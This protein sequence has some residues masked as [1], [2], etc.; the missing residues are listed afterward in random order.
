[1]TGRRVDSSRGWRD[2]DAAPIDRG[3]RVAIE[4]LLRG[5]TGMPA[6]V[7]A[8]SA[9]RAR[10]LADSAMTRAEDESPLEV[11]PSQVACGTP[12]GSEFRRERRP[13]HAATVYRRQGFR[14]WKYPRRSDRVDPPRAASVSARCEG[15]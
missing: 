10:R 13:T 7:S 15:R 3:S 4:L 5:G 12:A 6:R 2:R 9:R 8:P 14:Y 11:R 1:M